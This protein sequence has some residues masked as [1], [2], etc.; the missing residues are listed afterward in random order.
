MHAL[1]YISPQLS[2]VET[3][4]YLLRMHVSLRK[5][6]M[7]RRGKIINVIP[8]ILRKKRNAGIKVARSAKKKI[9]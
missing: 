9:V 8:E 3:G 1:Y 2:H 4:K 6:D 7:K 5:R